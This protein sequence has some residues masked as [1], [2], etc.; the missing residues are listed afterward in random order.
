MDVKNLITEDIALF[1]KICYKLERIISLNENGE[2][3]VSQEKLKGIRDMSKY[4]LGKR[5]QEINR[6]ISQEKE[7]DDNS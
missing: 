1:K 4:V 2:F 5:I 3:I 7:S 6:I